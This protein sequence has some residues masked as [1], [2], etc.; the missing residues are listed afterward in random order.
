MQWRGHQP[1]IATTDLLYNLGN[2]PSK[3]NNNDNDDNHDNHHNDNGA[4]GSGRSVHR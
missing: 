1:P 4:A 3:H 2:C